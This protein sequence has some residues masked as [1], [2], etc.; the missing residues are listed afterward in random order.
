MPLISNKAS[1]DNETRLNFATKQVGFN[2]LELLILT[3]ILC[4]VS[5]FVSLRAIMLTLLPVLSWLLPT[6]LL[7]LTLDYL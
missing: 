2:F 4:Y 5:K 7:A 3:Q 6:P 1:C